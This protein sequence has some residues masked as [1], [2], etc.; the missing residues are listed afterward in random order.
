MDHADGVLEIQPLA[1]EIGCDQDVRFERQGGKG[2]ALRSR[3]ECAEHVLPPGGLV[4]E[5]APFSG[6]GREAVAPKP[7]HQVL[8][9]G[10]WL[11]EDDRLSCAPLE[12]A[13]ERVRLGISQ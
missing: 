4:P 9:R 6:H 5:P 11:D 12:Q 1:Q 13:C 2:S 3:R 10:P 7:A 8:H